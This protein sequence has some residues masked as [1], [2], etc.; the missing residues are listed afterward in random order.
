MAQALVLA[1]AGAEIPKEAMRNLNARSHTRPVLF[2]TGR[3]VLGM[4]AAILSAS[5]FLPVTLPI[6]THSE[7]VPPYSVS[8]PVNEPRIFAEGIVSTVDD[9]SGAT[10]SPDGAD[11]YFVKQS[12]YTT[13]P[14]YGVICVSHFREGHW[15][16][17]EVVPFSGKFLDL[18]PK[19]SPDGK[20]ML[21]ASS[22]PAPG[23]DEHVLR[24]WSVEKKSDGWG[25]P[26]PLPEPVNAPA[27]FWNLDPSMTSDG[28]LYFTSDRG[29][30][31][32]FQIYRA[33]YSNL[34]YSEPEKLGPT[35]NSLYNDSEPYIS[36]DEKILLFA[37][38]GQQS[39]PFTARETDL[40]TGGRP[41]PRGDLYI[42]VRQN[43][44]WTAARHLEHWINTVGEESYP[45]L[46]PDGRYLYF[47]SERSSFVVPMARRLNYEAMERGLHS[48]FNGHGNIFFIDAKSLEIPP[49]RAAR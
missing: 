9:E 16:T 24:I 33:R 29:E 40:N 38:S 21:F 28:T 2:A 22:R 46:T 36:P 11:F 45:T 13:F 47:S 10:F 48:L 12:P 3:I 39:P 15:G 5:A 30:H 25:N 26:E 49:Q 34:K 44:A 17:P 6:T 1:Q 18:G 37:S 42:S 8:G 41:Y 7:K 4:A 32:H 31:F 19:L 20:V 14:R 27:G 35:I 43:G 23:H